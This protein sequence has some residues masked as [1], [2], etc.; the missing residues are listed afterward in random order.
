[1]ILDWQNLGMDSREFVHNYWQKKPC[2]LRNAIPDFESLISPEELAG[3]VHQQ[4]VQ[5]GLET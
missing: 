2:V 4:F 3:L 1:M 5:M